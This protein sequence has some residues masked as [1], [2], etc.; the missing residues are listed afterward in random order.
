MFFCVCTVVGWI[1]FWSLRSPPTSLI[2]SPHLASLPRVYNSLLLVRFFKHGPQ[3]LVWLMR[4]ITAFVCCNRLVL[5]FG[6]GVPGKQYELIKADG[7]PIEQY[8]AR[9]FDGVAQNSHL[10]KHNYFYY[11]C[12][13]GHFTPNNCP[14]YLKEANF[15][16]LKAGVIDRLTVATGTFLG[17]LRS[18]KYSKVIL[19][20]HLDWMQKAQHEEY[21]ATLA[22]QVVPGGIVI[23]RSAALHPPYAN[24]IADAGFDVKC[25]SSADKGYMD[26]WVCMTVDVHG[27]QHAWGGRGDVE[28]VGLGDGLHDAACPGGPTSMRWHALTSFACLPVPA[29]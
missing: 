7:V 4:K 5:W 2:L 29:G 15:A 9:T 25:I 28:W 26:K 10:K 14:A 6:G 16:R 21:A 18:R 19:M 1:S 3:F 20:D 17:E 11:N 23:W 13:T 12:L 8:I 22:Q 27:R 24:I